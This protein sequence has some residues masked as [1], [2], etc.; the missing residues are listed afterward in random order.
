[1][2][3]EVKKELKPT[4]DVRYE[5]NTDPRIPDVLKG[6]PTRLHQVLSYLLKNMRKDVT[7]G[8]F[9]VN[10]LRNEV[11]DNEMTL[12]IDVQAEGSGLNFK[13]VDTLFNQPANRENLESLN[14]NDME[15]VIVRRLVELQNGTIHA[16]QLKEDTVIT[17][18]LPFKVVEAAEIAQNTEGGNVPMYYNNYLEGKRIL[19]VE[20]NKV[21]QMLVMNMLK[22]KGVTVVA[23]NDGIEGLEALNRA[24]FDLILMDIQ[25]PRMDGYHAVAEIR[26]MK[27][28]Q[29]ANLPIVALTAS[30]YVTE[31]EKA[32]LFGMT[33]HIG[34]PF[35]PEEMLDKITRVLMSHNTSKNETDMPLI[36]VMS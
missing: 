17:I 19:V 18:F 34:K 27:N 21:N 26:R 32:Q 16:A 12:K 8:I 7:N 33:D 1:V 15:Y 31:K 14:E 25:M 11:I 3:Q 23:A 35:S 5:F 2:I 22:K 9:K 36:A 30:A 20:D 6:D 24:D 29:K 4:K 10:I 13:I 28:L